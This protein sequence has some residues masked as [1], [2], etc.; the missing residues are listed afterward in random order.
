VGY[1]LRPSGM[2]TCLP[3]GHGDEVQFGDDRSSSVNMRGSTTTGFSRA[4]NGH[5]VARRN[6]MFGVF[7]ICTA[8]SG[9]GVATVML[10]NCQGGA[11]GGDEQDTEWVIGAGA[12]ASGP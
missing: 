9:S 5:P 7:T 8:T 4:G 3:G 6:R 1:T 10:T 11:T 2:G 12:W